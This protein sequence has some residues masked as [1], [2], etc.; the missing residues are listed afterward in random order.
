VFAGVVDPD[1]SHYVQFESSDPSPNLCSLARSPDGAILT[2][3]GWDETDRT[4]NGIYTVRASDGGD[5]VR[6]TTSPDAGHDIP[7]DYSPNG[8]QIVFTRQR[9]P[10]EADVT[11]MVVNV[12]GSGARALSDRTLGAGRWSPDGTTILTDTG[13]SG[14]SLLL[15]PVDGGEIRT[16]DI[17]SDT[18]RTAFLG[19]LTAH[20]SLTSPIVK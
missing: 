20:S 8:D 5:L 9:L 10:D 11:L 17:V 15:V 7:T 6:V 13:E 3:A 16:I 14:G 4:R 1:G 12:D 19:G 18:L 2:C